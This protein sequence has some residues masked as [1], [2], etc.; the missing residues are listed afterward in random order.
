MGAVSPQEGHPIAFISKAFGPRNSSLSV[1]EKE[2]L[3]I[4]FAVSKWRHYLEQGLFYMKTDYESKQSLHTNLQKKG[5]SKLLWLEYK[6]LYR[7]GIRE[8]SG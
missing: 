3:A 1:Y 2:L 7:N 8:Q 6:I 5:I 4:T